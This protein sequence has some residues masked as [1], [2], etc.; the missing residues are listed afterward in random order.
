M[1]IFQ[2]SPVIN[3]NMKGIQNT[4]INL[5]FDKNHEKSIAFSYL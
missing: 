1:L 3:D 2:T 4:K 5:R